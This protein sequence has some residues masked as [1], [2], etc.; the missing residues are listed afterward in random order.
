MAQSLLRYRRVI[1]IVGD[2]LKVG[3]PEA[4]GGA[5]AVRLGDLATVRGVDGTQSLAQ[6]INI[7][8]TAVTLQVFSGTKGI[9]TGASATFLG[10]PMQVPYSEK[11]QIGRAHV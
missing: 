6:T 11:D 7:D 4:A 5:A 3:V 10:H 2:T 8:D 1:E 9:S